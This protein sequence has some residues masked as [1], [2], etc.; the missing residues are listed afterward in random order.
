MVTVEGTGT[1]TYHYP[2]HPEMKGSI[3]V[4]KEGDSGRPTTEETSPAPAEPIGEALIT[5]EK[6]IDGEGVVGNA[7]LGL[8]TGQKLARVDK[9]L[10]LL[11][12]SLT[13]PQCKDIRVAVACA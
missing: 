6:T 11:G 8:D 10:P 4:G 12:A 5:D 3:I 9:R 2:L 13:W 7:L 1:L